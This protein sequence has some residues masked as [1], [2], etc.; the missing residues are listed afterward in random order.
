M[1]SQGVRIKCVQG[2]SVGREP[3]LVDLDLECFTVLIGQW[4]VLT[5]SGSLPAREL[6]KY[7]VN[8][9]QFRDQIKHPVRYI[10]HI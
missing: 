6:L 4:A 9:A 2:V 7:I 3:G 5:H 10:N 8:P 1:R